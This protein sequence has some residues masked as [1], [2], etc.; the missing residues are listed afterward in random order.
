LYWHILLCVFATAWSY[1][2]AGLPLGA[3]R[4]WWGGAIAIVSALQSVYYAFLFV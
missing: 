1:R 3:R 4:F 2:C